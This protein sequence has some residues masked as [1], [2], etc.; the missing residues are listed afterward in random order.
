[1]AELASTCSDVTRY[2]DRHLDH[3]AAK[4]L[5]GEFFATD[6]DLVLV[7][8]LGSCVAACL[9]D[10]RTGIGG[11]NHFMLPDAGADPHERFGHSARYG[12][13]AMEM[14]INRLVAM[15]A[16]RQHLEAKVFGGGQVMADLR[17]SQVGSRNAAFVL[18]YLKEESIAVVARDLEGLYPRKVYF[19]PRT[20]RVL[21]KTLK[22]LVNDT[23]LRR[24]F[25]YGKRLRTVTVGGGVEPSR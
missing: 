22:T 12:M 21:V 13:Y 15:G 25:D 4:L 7:T 1:M 5:P 14:L 11:M 23:I 20:G 16:Q 10:R 17:S 19:F 18:R 24:E 2:H 9:R 8:V 3:E 6:E